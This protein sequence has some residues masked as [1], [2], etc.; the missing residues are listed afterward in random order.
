V[1]NT[2]Y[3]GNSGSGDT[4]AEPDDSPF[5]PLAPPDINVLVKW[6]VQLVD[7]A[8]IPNNAFLHLKVSDAFEEA[9]I[10]SVL[11]SSLE[12]LLEALEKYDG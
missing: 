11:E 7:R 4:G 8:Q 9:P 2:N 3:Y 12:V 10:G 1:S 6:L 5:A